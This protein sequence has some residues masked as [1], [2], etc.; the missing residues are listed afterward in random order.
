MSVLVKSPIG[1]IPW[2]LVIIVPDKAI[3][4][5]AI[6]CILSGDYTTFHSFY[7]FFCL[8][9]HRMFAMAYTD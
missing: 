1:L 6:H 9:T 7:F 8:F 3:R 2:K 4:R 5:P